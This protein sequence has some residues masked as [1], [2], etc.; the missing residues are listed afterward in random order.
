MRVAV[1]TL[2]RDRLD[3]S[4]HCFAK[5]AEHAGC[6]YDHY[7]FDNGSTDGTPEWIAREY[8]PHLWTLSPDN[9][10]ISKA[11]NVLLE[12][13]GK[14]GGYDVVVKFD[15]D[16]ELTTPGTLEVACRLVNEH[17][18]WIL[19]PRI[20]GLNS[21]PPTDHHTEVDGV[22]VAAMSMI[23]GIFMAVPADVY[24]AYRY[25]ETNPVWGMDDVGLCHWWKRD[26]RRR[27]GY[28]TDYPANHY[29]TTAGQWADMPWYWER[30][31]AEGLPL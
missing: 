3:Y 5:L 10:G 8:K 30:K 27:V 4:K 25:D 21:P 13:V 22:N 26:G 19:S 24:T 7:V 23:G 14:V 28:L 11:M 18:T 31:K 12:Y 1:L 2:T 6:D 29:L 20:E 17:P 15:N 16:C 9:I